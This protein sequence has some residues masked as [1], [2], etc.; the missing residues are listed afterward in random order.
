MTR[1]H[2]RGAVHSAAATANVVLVD[3]AR[4]RD[5]GLPAG[6]YQPLAAGD[7]VA[8]LPGCQRDARR[9]TVRIVPAAGHVDITRA[10]GRRHPCRL[11]VL[12][13]KTGKRAA[14]RSGA[15]AA[16]DIARGHPDALVSVR[17]AGRS[18]GPGSCGR[19]RPR[20]ADEILAIA[21]ARPRRARAGLAAALVQ[22]AAPWAEDLGAVEG[23][24]T[25]RAAAAAA[26]SGSGRDGSTAAARSGRDGTTAA[27]RAARNHARRAGAI[28]GVF[29]RRAA[30][31]RGT[32]ERPPPGSRSRRRSEVKWL[33]STWR[34]GVQAPGRIVVR[35]GAQGTVTCARR[36]AGSGSAIAPSRRRSR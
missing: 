13:R 11:T 21:G 3:A 14:L 26:R 18:P 17:H 27:A 5:R 34:R 20:P 15:K 19:R 33:W 32:P 28:P 2:F 35:Y 6:A 22:R 36:R 23:G 16:A 1:A 4:G 12:A 31:D 9:R 7:L 24:T 25:D 8:R 10:L 29:R 30:R